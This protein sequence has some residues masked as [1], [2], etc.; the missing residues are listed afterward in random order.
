[1][2]SNIDIKKIKGV[3]NM[4]DKRY[5]GI[6]FL[7]ID[8]INGFLV[9]KP[10]LYKYM[11]LEHALGTLKNKRLWLADPG[12]WEDP[13]EKRFLNARY[14]KADGTETDFPYS[15]RTFATCLT[16]DRSS[17]A[18]WNVY[19]RGSIG[20]KFV[21]NTTIL[22]EQL[23]EFAQ[24]H[25]TFKVFFGKVEY[26]KREEIEQKQL[27]KL[28]FEAEEKGVS[29]KKSLREKDFCARLFLLKR[30]DFKYEDEIRI[31]VFKDVKT[32]A[33]GTVFDYVCANH[34]LFPQ[35]MISPRVKEN[36]EMMLKEYLK[37]FDMDSFN[38]K[39]GR[40]QHRILKCH[41][42]DEN[43]VSINI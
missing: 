32:D 15:G 11:P 14:K 20:I 23:N 38:D 43:N 28:K 36:T 24:K 26:H 17:E 37:Q 3:V 30:H 16:R 33:K 41:L 31:I 9:D 27:L 21:I 19:S 2:V 34:E 6:E 12:T 4:I 7:N 5:P 39:S 18:Q 10:V 25:S 1:M 29:I 13:F 8:D 35:L 40:R 42:Y 22:L